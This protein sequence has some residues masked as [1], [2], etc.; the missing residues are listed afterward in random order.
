MSNADASVRSMVV[1]VLSFL[2]VHLISD[3]ETVR[4]MSMAWDKLFDLTY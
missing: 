3:F 2:K 4:N 1:Q